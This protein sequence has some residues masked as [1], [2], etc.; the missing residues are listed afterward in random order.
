MTQMGIQVSSDFTE[1]LAVAI[2]QAGHIGKVREAHTFSSKEWATSCP[3]RRARTNRL[4]SLRVGPVARRRA[5]P[6]VSRRLLPSE[7]MAETL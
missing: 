7:R 4:R 3:F 1:R 5:V 6:T 2:V